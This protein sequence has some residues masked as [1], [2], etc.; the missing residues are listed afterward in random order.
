[1]QPVRVIIGLGS[2]M[3]DRLIHLRNAVEQMEIGPVPA[4]SDVNYSS[5]YESKALLPNHAPKEWDM[6]FYN[7]AISGMC[8]RSPT[9][10]LQFLKQLE[11]RAGRS[12]RGVWAPRELD[13]DIL[14]YGNEAINQ[15]D[16]TIP[17]KELLR[18]DFALV[19][20]AEIEP[21]WLWCEPGPFHGKSLKQICAEL[22][23][24]QGDNLTRCKHHLMSRK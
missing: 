4:L 18:R 15:Q 22:G 10:L 21:D 8:S 9:D 6:P 20:M 23:M 1:M 11:E 24:G 16:L 3:G 12:Y 14:L 2:N 19:P 17:H 13:L 7:A 5:I